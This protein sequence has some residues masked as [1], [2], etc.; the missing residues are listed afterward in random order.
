MQKK[1]S[2]GQHFLR[3]AHYLALMADSAA[4][5]P[6]ERVLEVGPGDGALTRELLMRGAHVVAVEKDRRLIPVLQETFA[7]ELSAGNLQLVEGDILE[8]DVVN[9]LSLESPYKV[10]ANIPYYITGTLI[11]KLLTNEHQPTQL[12]FLVQK[13]VAERITCREHGQTA[14]SKKESLLSL[15]VKAYGEPQ[16][17]K[18]VPRGAF[19]PPPEVDSAVLLV[20]NISRKHFATPKQEEKFFT[21]IRAGFA[22]KRKLLARNLEPVLGDEYAEILKKVGISEKARAED[23]PLVL[24]LALTKH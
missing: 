22:Q 5:T 12:V 10:V 11:K 24:W 14:R 1:K 2:L 7:K 20:H 3:S 17:V 13:E 18:T 15:S 8:L 4:I 6:G 19:V 16:Y 21:L 23:I 9:D